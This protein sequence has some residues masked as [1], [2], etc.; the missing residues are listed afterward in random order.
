MMYI[1]STYYSMMYISST[2]KHT[3]VSPRPLARTTAGPWYG[4][5]NN[6]SVVTVYSDYRGP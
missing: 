1:S 3:S 5:N 4:E 6:V 2:S